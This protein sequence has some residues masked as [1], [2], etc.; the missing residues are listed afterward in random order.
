MSEVVD[1]SGIEPLTCPMIIG[2]LPAA[3]IRMQAGSSKCIPYNFWTQ[4]GS[5][6]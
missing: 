1:R 4:A 6:R 2:P 3:N 5:N